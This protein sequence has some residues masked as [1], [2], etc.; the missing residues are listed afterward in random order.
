MIK[1]RTIKL[2]IVLVMAVSSLGCAL[3]LADKALGDKK[4][5]HEDD[6]S[7]GSSQSSGNK[8]YITN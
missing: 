7:A 2:I 4:A 3:A 5:S 6:Q 8:G 1:W